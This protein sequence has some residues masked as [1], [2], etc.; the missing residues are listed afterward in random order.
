MEHQD[1]GKSPQYLTI[2]LMS[3]LACQGFSSLELSRGAIVWGEPR[4]QGSFPRPPPSILRS[5]EVD[6]N[7]NLGHWLRPPACWLG[8]C[9]LIPFRAVSILPIR[10]C[11]SYSFPFTSSKIRPIYKVLRSY[12]P[13]DPTRRRPSSVF[14]R[15]NSPTDC[16]VSID[17]T[18][19][20]HPPASLALLL[21]LSSRWL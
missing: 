5:T 19:T 8:G 15:C 9:A 18:M 10:P 1:F 13:I 11:I 2:L 20:E 12:Q 14:L 3:A 7:E 16:P 6:G 21:S 4:S 17:V